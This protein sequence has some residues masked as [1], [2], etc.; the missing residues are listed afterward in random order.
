[1]MSATNKRIAITSGLIALLLL[2]DSCARDPQKAKARYLAS[3]QNYMKKGKYGDA[4]VEFRNA[5]RLDPRFVEAYFQLAHADIAQQNWDDAYAALQKAIELDSSRLDARLDLARLYL[6]AR[7]FRQAQEDAKSILSKEPNNAAA[8]QL[9][10]ASLLA[11]QKREDA[12]QAFKKVTELRPDDPSAYVNL[13]LVEISLHNYPDAEQHFKKAVA[14]DPKF[15]EAYSDLA[16]FYRLNKQQPEAEQVLQEAIANNPNEA[17]LYLVWASMLASQGRRD[18]AEAILERLRKQVPNSVAAA[19]DIGD[20]YFQRKE[21]NRALVEYQK[22]LSISPKNKNLEIQKRMQDLYLSTGQIQQAA[23][24]DQELMKDAPTDIFV[25]INHGRLLL[26]QGNAPNAIT[27]LQKVVV[28]AADSEQAHYYL[29]MA[30][31]QNGDLGQARSAL[32]DVLRVKAELPIAL[33]ALGRLS[34]AQGNAADAQVYAQ[35]LIAKQRAVPGDYVLLAE[36]LARQGQFRSAEEQILIA[37]QLAPNDPIICLNLA[38]IYRLEKKW[39]ETQKEFEA[40]LQLDPHNTT[41][42]GQYADYL[43]TRNQSAEALVRVQ[44]YVT[45]NPNDA[46]G[47]VILGVV[48]DQS[49]NY[50]SAQAEFERAVQ[51]NPNHPQASILLAN[52]FKEQGKIDLAIA[53]YQKALDAQ[54]RSALLATAVGNL[55]LEKGD[56]ETARKYYAR[57]LEADPNFAVAL[58][59]TAWTYAQEGKNLDVALGMAQ[60]AKSLMPERPYSITDTL[61]WVMYK[62]G[63]FAEA[64]PMLRV[65]VQKSPESGEFHYHLGMSLMAAGQKAEGRKELEAALRMKLNNDADVQQAGQ[66]LAQLN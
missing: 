41:V 7:D 43:I 64:I 18:E 16:N 37:K 5:L 11:Q 56:L 47:H 38:Q 57:A 52:V 20:F 60:K 21:T 63:N 50:S 6:A 17:S 62:R 31:W 27:Y 35:E 49:K 13:A 30:Y 54:P 23:S 55:Y 66:A 61:A 15:I 53:Q 51:L 28:D 22:A 29:A 39:P 32:I 59:N 48:Y 65:C 8:Y 1:M 44:A 26:A 36:A 40:A 12:F 34:L 42:L 14:L 33:E 19:R 58:A 45:T 25:R 4:T 24:L 10:G 2:L 3:G 9:L 46:D